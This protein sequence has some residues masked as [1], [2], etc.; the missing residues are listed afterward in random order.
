MSLQGFAFFDEKIQSNLF[1]CFVCLFV[2]FFGIMATK[3]PDFLYGGLISLYQVLIK[4]V[5]LE[6]LFFSIRG[7]LNAVFRSL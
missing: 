3:C 6:S 4:K 7:P 5:V 1:A 2:F